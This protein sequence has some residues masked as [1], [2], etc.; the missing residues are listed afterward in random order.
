MTMFEAAEVAAELDA[1]LEAAG[2]DP[3]DPRVQTIKTIVSGYYAERTS[4]VL[5]KVNEVLD[6]VTDEGSR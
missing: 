1:R 2:V 6:K 3:T 4:E 5:T